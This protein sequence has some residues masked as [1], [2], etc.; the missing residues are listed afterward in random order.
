[1]SA[2][3]YDVWFLRR[4]QVFRAV[5]FEVVTEWVQQAKVLPEDK[6]K[7]VEEENWLALKDHPQF[8]IYLTSEAEEAS[9]TE[10]NS[11]TQ[12]E[13]DVGLDFGWKRRHTDED[14]DVD[15]I[16]LIDISLVL[17]IFFMMT[18][19]VAAISKIQVPQMQNAGKIDSTPDIIRLDIDWVG[20]Q[21]VYGVGL[22]NSVP[23]ADNGEINDPIV[24][25]QKLDAI[26]ATR[27]SP[28]KIRIA[29]HAEVPYEKV[30]KI[31][32]ELQKRIDQ[33]VRIA[34]FTVQVSDRP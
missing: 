26:L 33:G 15:M 30:D 21:A 22:G 24:L 8:S 19:T 17:L 5:P 18:T 7:S 27:T 16:P 13:P 28:A 32:A 9:Q 11:P 3:K 6:I 4:N 31:I 20:K 23:D 10:E 12:A 2:I 1:M 14:D 25:L 34:N 29:A